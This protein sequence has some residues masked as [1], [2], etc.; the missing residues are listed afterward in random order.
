MPT[1]GSYVGPIEKAVFPIVIGLN[2]NAALPAGIDVQWQ[3][4]VPNNIPGL[5]YVGVDQISLEPG[6]YLCMVNLTHETTNT[7]NPQHI[8]IRS[9][10][11]GVFD[12]LLKARSG[13]YPSRPNP[14]SYSIIWQFYFETTLTGTIFRINSHQPS[15]AAVATAAANTELGQLILFK[16]A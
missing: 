6:E 11:N 8:T 9:S 3:A 12:P 13:V 15:F 2:L 7:T 14:M 10:L 5:L 4:P 16:I 1:Q